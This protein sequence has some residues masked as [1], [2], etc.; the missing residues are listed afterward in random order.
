LALTP[1]RTPPHF[2]MPE[3]R[4]PDLPTQLVRLT[5][6]VCLIHLIRNSFRYA[7]RKNWDELSRDL[8]PIYTAGN[9]EAAAAALDDLHAKWGARYPAIIRLWRNAWEEFIPFLDYGGSRRRSLENPGSRNP[10]PASVSNHRVVT[11]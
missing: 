4:P 9:A 11:S 7:S 1:A 3:P 2:G 5:A 8:K 10:S 6:G